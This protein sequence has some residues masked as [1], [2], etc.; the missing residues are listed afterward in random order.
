MR[1]GEPHPFP[2]RGSPTRLRASGD[3]VEYSVYLLYLLVLPE[4]VCT[5]TWNT[6]GVELSLCWPAHPP[7]LK[8]TTCIVAFEFCLLA[9]GDP[10]FMPQYSKLPDEF[11]YHPVISS[12]FWPTCAAFVEYIQELLTSTVLDKCFVSVLTLGRKQSS[13]V[14]CHLTDPRGQIAVY[15][16]PVNRNMPLACRDTSNFDDKDLNTP[17]NVYGC[18]T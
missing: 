11:L 10:L 1:F 17:V 6:L 4:S 12:I 8:E 16:M 15:P 18:E 9:A 13:Y 5:L 2:E 7:F 14:A 3:R